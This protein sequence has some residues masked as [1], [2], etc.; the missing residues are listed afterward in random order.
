[1]SG[2]LELDPVRFVLFSPATHEA[3]VTALST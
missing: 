1:M 2:V 3:L